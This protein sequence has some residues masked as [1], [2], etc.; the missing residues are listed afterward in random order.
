MPT[1]AVVIWQGPLLSI[2]TIKCPP[3]FVKK[4]PFSDRF[5]FKNVEIEKFCNDT[6]ELTISKNNYQYHVK[7][8]VMKETLTR[9]IPRGLC[10]CSSFTDRN[11][12][13]FSLDFCTKGSKQ[14]TIF[15]I[16]ASW[17]DHRHCTWRA[18]FL[19]S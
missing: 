3:W 17:T 10:S 9:C 15:Q 5:T 6:D 18:L 1:T 4:Q 12:N 7:T 16:N 14:G 8:Q 13:M 11:P 19:H 2:S